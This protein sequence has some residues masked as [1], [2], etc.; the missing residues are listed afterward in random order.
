MTQHL[1]LEEQEQL[2]Q[3]KHFWATYGNLITWI[4]IAVLGSFAGWN[5]YQYWQRNQA[6]QAALLYDE[7]DRAVT[8]NDL[9][10][11]ER[12]WADM[13][14]KF[15][16]TTYAQQAGLLVAKAL[17]TQNKANAAQVTLSRVIDK[18]KDEGLVAIARLR[19]AGLLVQQQAYDEALKQLSSAMPKGFEPLTQDRRADIFALQGKKAEAVAEYQKAYQALDEQSEYR[20]LI[21]V[22][23]TA[24]GADPV[25]A[26]AASA[27]GEAK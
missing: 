18:S 7:L 12:S 24:M 8:A 13:Q 27:Q 22:K 5:G 17:Q 10:R 15:D 21:E 23:L 2:D 11:I 26:K 16:S 6:E 9:A 20:R 4:L 3:L 1:D 14:D 25:V 19:L